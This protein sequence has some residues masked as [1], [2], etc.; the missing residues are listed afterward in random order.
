MMERKKVYGLAAGVSFLLPSLATAALPETVLSQ[1]L[2]YVWVALCAVLV[3]IMQAGFALL[4]GGSSRAKNTI[5][6]IMKNYVDFCVGILAFWCIGFG[7]MFGLNS[8]GWIGTD[9][10]L[11][12]LSN[13][14]DAVFFLFQSMFAATT[15]TIVSGAVAERMRFMPYVLGTVIITSLIYPLFGSWVW[16]ALD[17]GTGWLNGLGFIDF[18]GSTVV[19][20]VGGWCALA[21]IIVLGPRLGRFAR[22][23][24]PRRIAGHNLTLVGLG[25]FL[26]WFGWFGFNG[27]SALAAD[28]ILGLV[29]VN[30]QLAGA[31]GVVGALATM[32]LAGQPIYM[33]TAINGSLGGLVSVT[34]GCATL[35]TPFA[36]LAGFIGG[37]ITVMGSKLL[38]R[39][40]L[41]DVVDAVSVHGFCGVWGTL[42][43]GLFF[44]GDLFNMDRVF[45]QLIGIAS[46]FIWT[47]PVA[48]VMFKAI[49]LLF[50]LRVDPIHEQRGLDYS[51]HY[52]IGYPEFQADLTNRGFENT[53]TLRGKDYEQAVTVS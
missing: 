24:S 11:P 47:F 15:A 14:R 28:S 23:G 19:H 26:L 1:P 21:A 51:E 16:G 45:I 50:G 36:I 48:L 46:A 3:F 39:L 7:L 33:T 25:V 41:D 42:A 4:E 13:P 53:T 32:R 34:A 38:Q 44:A 40:K 8:T 35:A 37:L 52:E 22:D 10:F 18:A 29:L 2:D 17:E 31:A 43:A 27:G 5:N 12:T 9:H 6:V 49:D 20:S 30:T